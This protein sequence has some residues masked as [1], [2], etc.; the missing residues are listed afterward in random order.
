MACVI[1][2]L[3]SDSLVTERGFM[4]SSGVAERCDLTLLTAVLSSDAMSCTAPSP[5]ALSAV[6]QLCPLRP[7]LVD[8]RQPA[9]SSRSR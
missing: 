3:A 2:S 9:C 6:E 8:R 5:A 1:V 4:A 7:P